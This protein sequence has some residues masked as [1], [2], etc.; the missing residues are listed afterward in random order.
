MNGLNRD[1][2]HTGR[3]HRKR[4]KAPWGSPR[5]MTL[6]MGGLLARQQPA[7]SRDSFQFLCVEQIVGD[8]GG[9]VGVQR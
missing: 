3:A 4:P 7:R 2:E 6:N 9:R 1:T 8:E 5:R